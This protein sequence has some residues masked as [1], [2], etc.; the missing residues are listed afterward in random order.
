MRDAR[1][2][3][4]TLVA[5]GVLAAGCKPAARRSRACGCG[6]GRRGP[7]RYRG[8]ADAPGV[9]A[10][11]GDLRGERPPVHPEGTLAGVQAH[12]PRLK[13]LGVDVIWLMPVQP[14]GKKNRKGPLG[15]YYSIADYTAINPE[16]GTMADFDALV[17]A[18]HAR[19]SRC[20]STGCPITPRSTTRGSRSTRTTTS[21]APT[22]PI[23]NARDNEGHDTD[24]TDVA[25]LNYDNPEMRTAMIDDMRFWLDRGA[26]RRLPR[27]TSPAACRS[28]SGS[29]PAPRSR[30]RGPTSSCSPRRRT[31]RCTRRST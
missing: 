13:A 25:E 1:V 22:A 9:V 14:I 18:A 21:R 11:C 5:L 23:I 15:S 17:A 31:R 3:R 7:R 26:R 8:H 28:T 24:W 20:C 29:R 12:L 16:F 2:M 4:R 30:S 19:G 27:A 6:A 10:Q